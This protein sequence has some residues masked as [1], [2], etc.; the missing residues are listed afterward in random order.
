MRVLFGG[1]AFWRCVGRTWRAILD[2]ATR[3]ARLDYQLVVVLA[4]A[5]AAAAAG[6][7]GGLFA[8]LCLDNTIDDGGGR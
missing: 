2:A 5:V 7:V 1:G 6:A 8:F 4:V 3:R